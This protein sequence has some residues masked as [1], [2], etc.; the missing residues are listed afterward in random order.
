MVAGSP[1]ILDEA[2]RTEVLNQL[3]EG[4]EQLHVESWRSRLAWRNQDGR[5]NRI[6]RRQRAS[7]TI[8]RLL[9]EWARSVLQY[10]AWLVDTWTRV[11]FSLG[12]VIFAPLDLV[13][14][15]IWAI[16]GTLGLGFALVAG[17]VLDVPV[18]RNASDRLVQYLIAG[19][20]RPG[21]GE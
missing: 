15:L 2:A 19:E 21:S 5:Q 11:F 6:R 16:G 17:M 13:S 10:L 18:L 14:V 8:W 4:L 12:S 20:R 1:A 3:E 9:G 7:S